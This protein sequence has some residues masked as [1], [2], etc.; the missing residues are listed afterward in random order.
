[1]AKGEILTQVIYGNLTGDGATY[2]TGPGGVDDF[3]NPFYDV[4]L[5]TN[6]RSCISC[7][8]I[9]SGWSLSPTMVEK[10]FDST[11]GLDPL[12]RVND[13]ANSPLADV[14]TVDA[15]RTAYSLLLY[16]GLIRVGLAI[17]AGAEF[18]LVAVE[19]P[20]G[21]A[22]AAE[23]SLFRRPLPAANL[24]FNSTVMWDGR[25]PDLTSQANSAILGHA[26]A[27][28][29]P[30]TSTLDA[31]VAFES[32]LFTTQLM[33]FAAGDLTADGALGGPVNHAW[34]TY[35]PGVNDPRLASFDPRVFTVFD[36]WTNATGTLAGARQSVARGQAI[37]NE[38]QFRISPTRSGTCGTCHNTP[39]VGNSSIGFFINIG[40]A[41]EQH[42]TPDLPLYTLRC[43]T[44]GKLH[45][46]SDPG[47]ALVTG[48]CTDIG[49]FKVPSLRGLAAR[50]PYFHNGSAATLEDAV[51][52]K[53][54]HFRLGLTDQ[55]RADL[56]AFLSAL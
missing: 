41:D 38:R 29:S 4:T 16:K 36:A 44:T 9:P 47:R 23:L 43:S 14:S 40:T 53:D 32:G 18:T 10:L 45:K 54:T 51:I 27:G 46:T 3:A 5:G 55:E 42:R 20:Y 50:P 48:K 1:M 39:N 26:Q 11:D 52:Y 49:K 12:F 17:P 15:R 33:D 24:P 7:H 31:I 2:A 6:G 56:V 30:A 28:K 8:R 37:F 21:Y 34:Q 19:D 13:G 35:S 25:E 22:S